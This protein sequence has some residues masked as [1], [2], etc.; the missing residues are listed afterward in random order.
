MV[1]QLD[2][3]DAVLPIRA[4]ARE[5]GIKTDTPDGEM[6]CLI[7][8]AL[9]FVVALRLGDKLPSELNG[10]EASWKPTEQDRRIAGSRVRRELVRCVSAHTGEPA[11]IAGGAEPGWE[12]RGGNKEL[13]QKAIAG[14]ATLLDKIA[15]VEVEVR[16][17]AIAEELACIETMRRTLTRGMTAPQ[18]KLLRIKASD[19][20]ASRRD[21]LQQVQAL[22]RR[23]LKQIMARFDDVD[24]RLDDI[25]AMLRDTAKAIEWLRH[26]RDWLF[27][28]NHAWEPVFTDWASASGH[29]DA[30]LWKVVERSYLFLAPRFM[31]FQEWTTADGKVGKQGVRA[32]VW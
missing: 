20:P 24:A 27:C 3:Q 5:F 2:D 8:Q 30:F 17:S 22:A 7:E 12:N 26:Q 16:I 10:G 18:E 1:V 14:A 19:L 23:G 32:T 11:A 13:L 6:L 15:A 4:V 21:T 9:D 28:T 25:L 29:I 31:T